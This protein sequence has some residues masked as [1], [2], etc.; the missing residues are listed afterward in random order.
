[1]VAGGD[2]AQLS[3]AVIGMVCL[4]VRPDRPNGHGA[5]W[6]SLDPHVE[7]VKG[8]VADDLTLVKINILLARRGIDVP[9][10]TLHRWA[11]ANADYGRRKATV[12]VADGEPGVELQVDFGKM[13]LVPEPATGRRRVVHALIFVACYSRHCFV[14]LTHRQTTEAVIEGFE[15][16]WAFY[17]GVFAVVIPD[18]MSPIV[19]EADPTEP[20]FT[21]AFVEYSQSRGF[22]IDA[23]RVRTPTDKPRVERC[24]PYVRR[25]FF[26]GEDFIDL[27]DAQRRA[28]QWCATTAGLRVHGTTQLHPAEVFAVEEAPLLLAAPDGPYDLP[29]YPTPKVHRDRH[30]EVAKALYSVPGELIG[31]RVNV[32]ADAKLIKIFHRGELIRVHPR[33]APGKRQTDASDL[34]S[35]KTAYAM[36]DI[37]HLRR[38]AADEGAAVGS[39]ADALLGGPLPWTKMRQVYRLL[40]LVKRWGAGRVDAACAKALE[41]ETVNVGLIERMLERATEAAEAPPAPEAKILPGRFARDASEYAVGG[42]ER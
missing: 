22:A 25:N 12:R 31:I 33:V 19:V 24:V 26:A 29:T 38:M 42:G 27:A 8:W 30:I 39:Y 11:A 21:D 10:R 1:V 37:D 35:D 28:E 15:A 16:A 9:Y 4:R 41:V 6:E 34:P 2:E 14:F 13:G 17:G 36:R 20:R 40:G 5:A 3:D 18:N 23:A 7:L 32:R